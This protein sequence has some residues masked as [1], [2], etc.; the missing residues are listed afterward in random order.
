MN[1]RLTGQTPAAV[2]RRII[3]TRTALGLSQGQFSALCGVPQQ[4]LSNYERGERLPTA[5]SAAKI[6]AA[7]KATS[8]GWLLTGKRDVLPADL[9]QRIFPEEQP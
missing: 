1:T 5:P 4:T 9:R 7:I 2:A 8:T 3:A 6:S